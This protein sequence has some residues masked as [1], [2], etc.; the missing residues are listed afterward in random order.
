MKRKHIIS[1]L[2]L[3]FMLCIWCMGVFAKE[4]TIQDVLNLLSK[5]RMEHVCDPEGLLSTEAT[6]RINQLLVDIEDSLGVEVAVVALNGIDDLSPKLFAFDLFQKWGIGSKDLDDRLLIQLIVSPTLQDISFEMSNGLEGVLPDLVCHRIQYHTMLPLW[7][8]GDLSGA[9]VVGV[10]T[11]CQ[12][13]YTA[14][15]RPITEKASEAVFGIL[16]RV[17]F[18]L[19]VPVV[20]LVLIVGCYRTFRKRSKGTCCP[21]C[22]QMVFRFNGTRCLK[23]AT[24]ECEGMAISEWVCANCGYTV[25]DRFAI[26]KTGTRSAENSCRSSYIGRIPF[27]PYYYRDYEIHP[28]KSTENDHTISYP[29][30][31]SWGGGYSGGGGADTD[32]SDNDPAD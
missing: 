21:K 10:D 9:M 27:D 5:N 11:V 20:F 4:Y 26:D 24:D 18:F 14:W 25:E 30:G 1:K 2:G 15:S 31:G 17:L 29:I 7:K 13:L 22:H 23:E 8:R 6:G 19:A 16:W 28:D 3:A 12:R 32:F